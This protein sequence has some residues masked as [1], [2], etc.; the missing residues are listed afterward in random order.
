[1]AAL[2]FTYDPADP[3][4][5]EDPFPHYRQLREQ[6]NNVQFLD[7]I[8]AYAIARYDV[9]VDALRSPHL[10]GNSDGYGPGFDWSYNREGAAP[11]TGHALY[12]PDEAGRLI[13][14]TDPP[15][16]SVIRRIVSRHFTPKAV[17]ALGDYVKAQAV[18]AVAAI[19]ERGRDGEIID[20]TDTF[21]DIPFRAI[22][23]LLG[24]PEA[25][26]PEFKHATEVIAYGIGIQRYEGAMQEAS[27]SLCA[28]FD[29]VVTRRAQEPGDDLI[30]SIIME[31]ANIDEPLSKAEIA[32]FAMFLFAAGTDTTSGALA[33]WFALSVSGQPEMWPSI[34]NDRS[35]IGPSLEEVFRFLNSN[36]V[37]MRHVLA[38]TSFA[39]ADMPKGS[40]LWVLLGAGNRDVGHF[41]PDAEEYRIGRNPVDALGFGF[42]IHHC[43]GAPLARL[44]GKA[45]LTALVEGTGSIQ[46]A[47]EV[48]WN[49]HPWMRSAAHVPVEVS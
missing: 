36:Q 17:A 43:L 14:L 2:T 11:G 24:I 27:D 39:G 5:L 9:A 20:L 45:V 46:P 7:S 25:D 33:N 8:G 6:G 4:V 49:L 18:G 41:G 47:A 31:S 22:L 38:D 32:A 10:F 42:G 30:S 21:S 23:Q 37:A 48:Q 16:H 15:E 12:R 26:T 19:V 35:L 3:A 13:L 29:D 28:F 34:R 1:M 40:S 44:E